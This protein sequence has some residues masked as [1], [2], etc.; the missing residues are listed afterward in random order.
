MTEENPDCLRVDNVCC[1]SRCLP[2]CRLPSLLPELEQ[3]ITLGT[4]PFTTSKVAL[5]S[6]ESHDSPIACWGM[7]WATDYQKWC[8]AKGI[9]LVPQ[10]SSDW[11]TG[12]MINSFCELKESLLSWLCNGVNWSKSSNGETTSVSSLAVQNGT[13]HFYFPVL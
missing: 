11:Q 8:K 1:S 13:G 3:G 12:S 2:S 6:S 4:C 5:S 7:E 10:G 9:A